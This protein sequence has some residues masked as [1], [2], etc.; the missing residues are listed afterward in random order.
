[1]SKR[2][3]EQCTSN[4]YVFV[5][6]PGLTL[7]DL[8]HLEGFLYLRTHSLKA[9]TLG[10][11]PR[12]EKPVDF[13]MLSDYARSKCSASLIE[14]EGFEE[15]GTYIDTKKRV[16]RIDFPELPAGNETAR[17]EALKEAGTCFAL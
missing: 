11:I 4:A 5:N 14:L 1:M 16:I 7:E 10:L 15:V 2:L 8:Q 13:N 9:S 6:Q 3:I 12:L 17:M